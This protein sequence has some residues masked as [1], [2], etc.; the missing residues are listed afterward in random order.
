MKLYPFLALLIFSQ[1]VFAQ[2]DTAII[3]TDATSVD[4][5]AAM[6]AANKIGAPI[7][8]TESGMVPDSVLQALAAGNMKTVILAG[9]PAVIKEEA[10]VQLEGLGYS[11]V[12][13]WGIERTGTALE[14]AKYFWAE[15]LKCAV[16][17][18]DTK[19]SD[20]DT[21]LQLEASVFAARKSCAMIP[22]PKGT[23]PAEVLSSLEGLNVSEVKFIGRELRSEIREKLNKF[24][25]EEITGSEA[26]EKVESELAKNA[27][28]LVVVAAPEWKHALSIG[29][30]PS[31]NSVV[32]MVSSIGQ[33]SGLISFIKSGSFT[34][35]KVVG[36][37]SLA[38]D[39][40]AALAAENITVSKVTGEKAS[41]VAKKIWE[42]KKESWKEIR[43]KHEETRAK[44][45]E[46]V[47][48]RLKDAANET[49]SELDELEIEL[50]ESGVDVSSLKA[51]LAEARA[52]VNQALQKLDD[53]TTAERLIA[54]A[55]LEFKTRMWND[56][57]RI[58]WNYA[59][60]LKA[61][62]A[63]TDE[64]EKDSSEKLDAVEK[65]TENLRK[66][67]KSDAIEALVERAKSLG[68]TAKDESG[69]G[70]HTKAA[71]LRIEVKKLVEQA[72]SLG[73]ICKK[74][75]KI[76]ETAEKIAEK[77]ES[78]A[79]KVLEKIDAEKAKK[80]RIIKSTP[81]SSEAK[82]VS[83]TMKFIDIEGG[84]W[85]FKGD[86]GTNY[87]L[88]KLAEKLSAPLKD[89][90]KLTVDVKEKE[91]A[92]VCQVGKLA[93]VVNVVAA[94]ATPKSSAA[95]K[96]FILET[97]DNG[98]YMNGA[99]IE[100]LEVDKGAKVKL[101]F[102]FRDDGIY[103]GG[104]DISSSSPS[105]SFQTIKYTKGS[106]ETKSAEFTASSGFKVTSYWPSSSSR[107]ASFDVKVK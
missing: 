78:K 17:T 16:I 73:N 46:K 56:R 2:V 3:A 74:E 10:K 65:D 53:I 64:I 67:C 27:T 50:E 42:E 93:E 48:T 90:L 70:N 91:G 15:G 89:G 33:L 39:I 88:T 94:T 85:Q 63:G 66:A 77:R 19:D 4:A 31:E 72:K 81:L 86:N 58:K 96:E 57:M 36:V 95:A 28:R 68:E 102:K 61:E 104:L 103:Y 41:E 24:R 71:V 62:E 1:L 101:A 6:A 105:V 54:R 79:V 60:K 49:E 51:D 9:G 11:V 13:L 25:T 43:E 8:T 23:M 12:R 32:K 55:K 21:K 76:S 59:A 84:C 37:P 87:E 7:F 47:K 82:R 22:V 107:K 99:K 106:N 100:N 5:L 83:G 26:E 44:V 30:H 14:V 75:K 34:G 40:A 69:K 29:A 38:Q 80:L 98:F 97:D 45:K 92:S 18:D 35:I 52:L 20:A